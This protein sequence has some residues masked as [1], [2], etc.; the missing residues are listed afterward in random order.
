MRLEGQATPEKLIQKLEYL[1]ENKFIFRGQ[2]SRAFFLLPNAFRGDTIRKMQKIYP[3][4]IKY[5]KWRESEDLQKI[6]RLYFNDT[7][8]N[9]L[10]A[11]NIARLHELTIY[12]L[13]YNYFIAKYISKFPEK[14]DSASLSTQKLRSPEFWIDEESFMYFFGFA[15]RVSTGIIL[16]DGS[17]KNSPEINEILT[18]YDESLPQHYSVPTAALDW[19]WNP[20][21]AIFFALKDIPKNVKEI[22]IYAYKEIKNEID[23]PI[24]IVMGNPECRNPRIA[25]QEGLFM[26]LRYACFYYYMNGDWPSV[27]IF[28]SK[29]RGHFELIKFTI[30]ISYINILR[31]ICNNEGKTNNFLFPEKE[32][33][34]IYDI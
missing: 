22:A 2:P 32:C 12:L 30:D 33:E 5:N 21:I 28:I 7:K 1:K 13:Q 25:H 8:P 3:S 29:N 17:I 4:T 23:N 14:F 26:K 19:T 15:L 11:I 20:Y 16:L 34:F 9:P 31:K 10:V 6:I 27:E 24:T 18:A